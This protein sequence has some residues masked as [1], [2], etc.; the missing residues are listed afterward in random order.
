MLESERLVIKPFES[1]DLA[2]LFNLICDKDLTY[3]AGFK[4]VPDLKTC[5]LSLQYRIA[6]KQYVKLLSKNGE[7]IGEINFYKDTSKRNPK[8]YEIGFMINKKYH[9]QGYATEALK[10]FIPYFYSHIDVDIL[11]AHV[12]VGNISSEKTLIKLGFHLDGVIRRYKRMY[13]DNVLDVSEFSL[14]REEIE[15]NIKLWQQ[16]S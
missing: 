6:S 8:A 14:T 7:F 16:K 15:R 10:T 12:F 4:P 11:S 2:D 3:P 5:Q 13:D 9:R 1:S